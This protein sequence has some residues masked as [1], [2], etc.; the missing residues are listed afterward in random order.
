MADRIILL[1]DSDILSESMHKINY[2]FKLLENDTAVND[3]RWQQYVNSIDKKIDGLKN[4]TDSRENALA[5]N[6]DSLQ[7]LI[8][9]MATKEDIQNQINHAL[10]NAN[11]ELRGFISTAVGQQVSKAYGTFATTSQLY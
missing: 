3:Y 8:D 4:A 10:Q 7:D 2:N 6:L 5:R 9:S 1:K 11:D